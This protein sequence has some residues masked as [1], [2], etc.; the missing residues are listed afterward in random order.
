[1]A[2]TS[3]GQV[4]LLT[5]YPLGNSEFQ[6]YSNT[7]QTYNIYIRMAASMHAEIVAVPQELYVHHWFV[8]DKTPGAAY[9]TATDVFEGASPWLYHVKHDLKRRFSVKKKLLQK[10]WSVGAINQYSQIGPA[11]H[12][13]DGM[14]TMWKTRIVTNWKNNATGVLSDIET[15]AL[16]WIC[17]ISSSLPAQDVKWTRVNVYADC[18]LYFTCI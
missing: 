12:A 4:R 7:T 14:S 6:R 10:V 13:V 1:M 11:A 2:V 16:L 18:T 15:G 5:S 17:V 9:P 8:K 3:D